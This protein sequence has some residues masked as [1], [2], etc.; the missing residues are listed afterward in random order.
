MAENL[1]H[2]K[3]CGDHKS[4]ESV[5]LALRLPSR[6]HDSPVPVVVKLEPALYPRWV[7]QLSMRQMRSDPISRQMEARP[8]SYNKW[9]RLPWSI[10]LH[11]RSN[12]R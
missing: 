8:R 3:E 7:P 1:G 9:T 12:L 4:E 2:V 10:F 5:V 6:N 11:G